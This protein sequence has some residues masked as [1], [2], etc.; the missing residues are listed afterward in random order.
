MLPQVFVL[1]FK[2][3][4]LKRID[5]MRLLIP[6]IPLMVSP[7]RHMY[8]PVEEKPGLIFFQQRKEHLEPLMGKVSRI[9]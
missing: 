4:P 8:M 3:A 5:H 6:V 1:I 2:H 7:V 9:I